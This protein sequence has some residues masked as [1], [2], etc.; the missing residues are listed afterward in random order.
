MSEQ[1]VFS[2]EQ[3][4]QNARALFQ[5][6]GDI[7]EK[8]HQLTVEAL[9]RRQLAEQEIRE[10]L[11]A[12]SEGVGAGA[13]DRAE[14]VRESLRQAMNGMDDALGHAAEAMHLA[15]GEVSSHAQEFAEQDLK[16]CISDLKQLE[17][18]FLDTVSRAG[19]S[20][21]GLVKQ[22]MTALA[23]HA[24]HSGTGIGQRVRTVAEELAERLR[25]TAQQAGDAGKQAAR[26]VGARAAALASD[27][28]SE[29]ARRIAEKAEQ[30]KQK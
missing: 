11:G 16:Q 15:W 7:R 23:E 3:I 8:L 28:L 27:K 29:I 18:M 4:K 21:G 5:S 2:V 30:L 1:N 25:A 13:A 22:E 12:I 26:E 9:T 17:E 20:A 24:R 19:Q 14:E 6:G 10:V